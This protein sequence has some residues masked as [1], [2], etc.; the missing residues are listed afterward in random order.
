MVVVMLYTWQFKMY[1]SP[2]CFINSVWRTLA[3]SFFNVL[4]PGAGSQGFLVRTLMYYIFSALCI[5]M[6]YIFSGDC[7]GQA[8]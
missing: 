1:S 4:M 8:C 3:V 5:L 7:E 2:D 6:H